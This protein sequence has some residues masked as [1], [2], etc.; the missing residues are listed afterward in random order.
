MPRLILLTLLLLCALTSVCAADGDEPYRELLYPV[1]AQVLDYIVRSG[2]AFVVSTRFATPDDFD[3]VLEFY[4]EKLGREL[5]PQGN[6]IR[7]G[8]R[9]PH[10]LVS[11]VTN[12]G[13]GITPGGPVLN[14]DKDKPRGI[15]LVTFV[16]ITPEE[17]I[18][19]VI[20][21]LDGEEY[22]HIV[23]THAKCPRGGAGGG[24]ASVRDAESTDPAGEM[25]RAAATGNVSRVKSLIDA[26]ASVNDKDAE[27]RTPVM[28]AAANGHA[29]LC[30]TLMLQGAMATE[31]DA[32]GRTALM[33][34]AENGHAGVVDALFQMQNIA[35]SRV[36]ELN[37]DWS[38]LKQ[39]DVESR[40]S[41][42]FPIATNAQ[43]NDG[44][45][46]QIK[47]AANGDMNCLRAMHNGGIGSLQSSGRCVDATLRDKEGRT[48]LM[49][50]VINGHVN[51]IRD[52]AVPLERRL[53]SLSP[54]DLTFLDLWG[55]PVSV[56][57]P[58]LLTL[59]SL[60][61]SDNEGRTAV[62]LADERD[63]QAIADILHRYLDLLI[64]NADAV[65]EGGGPNRE[66]AYWGRGKVYEA[67]GDIER[68]E[69]D[70][71]L[72]REA[73]GE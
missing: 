52:L 58:E 1:E 17:Q 60:R 31:R 43:D 41:F 40:D 12:D 70:F 67:L 53:S 61:L 8:G 37:V 18:T 59:E 4:A 72:A 2:D 64:S 57:Q 46:A 65:V 22:T 39:V 71:A 15:N 55:N 16:K 63:D 27:G 51:L 19:L 47:A 68:A 32:T 35:A 30:Q 33:H 73:A 21:R 11:V 6:R 66:Y 23:L 7:I 42:H 56:V 10:P 3:T 34:A 44:E 28:I 54:D 50:A 20:S 26:G 5:N 69:A 49:H 45:T 48:A 14:F 24:N 62:Q 36:R 29:A 25:H 13:L 9:D 38:I